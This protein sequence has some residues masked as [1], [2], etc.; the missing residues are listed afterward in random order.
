MRWLIKRLGQSEAVRGLLCWLAAQYIRM[1]HV[2]GPWQVRDGEHVAPFLKPKRPFI[3]VFWHGRLLMAPCAWPRGRTIKMLIS[4]HRD[5]E[6]IART[7]AHFGIETVRGSKSR[8]GSAALRTMMKALEAGDDVGITPD[9]PRGPRMR[10]Q[11][12]AIA[13]A[14]LSGAP[15]VPLTFSSSRRRVLGSWDRFIV[16]LPF[17]RGVLLWGE[18]LSVPRDADAALRETLR[19]E[20]ERR[21]NAL[22]AEADRLAGHAPVEPEPA[23]LSGA[24][25]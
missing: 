3:L 15:I 21:M 22:T 9:G 6:L 14:S 17:G 24:A 20:L 5:G 25:S 18:P 1:V 19:L 23:E 10:V 4:T 16:A 8:G 7:V 13:L 12:G 2:S 11:P